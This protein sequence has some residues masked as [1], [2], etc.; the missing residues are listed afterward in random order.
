M[1][2]NWE[3]FSKIKKALSTGLKA[4]NQTCACN[5][6]SKVSI[7]VVLFDIKELSDTTNNEEL[8]EILNSMILKATNLWIGTVGKDRRQIKGWESSVYKRI[9]KSLNEILITSEVEFVEK[10]PVEPTQ[11][12]IETKAKTSKKSSK[13]KDEEVVVELTDDEIKDVIKEGNY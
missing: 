13:K 11:A 8:R 2:L 4:S 9:Y 12:I 5:D 7:N 3:D 10:T 6:T 1:K